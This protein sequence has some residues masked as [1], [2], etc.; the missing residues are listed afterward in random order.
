M[1]SYPS[2]AGLAGVAA[3]VGS[4]PRLKLI[5]RRLLI[6]VPVLFG[7]T[8][9][10]FFILDLLPGSA[11]QQ[12]L[13]PD[14]TA[15]QV[16]RLEAQLDLDQPAWQR[17]VRWIADV[18]KGDLGNSFASGQPVRQ[19]LAERLPVTGELVLCAFL[20]SILTAV[21][22]AVV[23]A[24]YPGRI[25]DR[26]ITLLSMAGL[27]AANYVIALLLVLL[28]SVSLRLFPAIGFTPIS[29]GLMKNLHSLALPVLAIALPLSC[30]YT[31]F[32]RGDLLAQLY[33]KDYVITAVAKGLGPWRVVIGHALRN[34]LFGLLTLVGLNIGALL[35]GTVVVEQIFA[36]PGIGQLLLQ[37]INTRDADVVQA[38]VLL[39]ALVTVVA[40][41]SVD[42]LYTALDPRVR[43][44]RE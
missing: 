12:L 30:F 41:L 13:G 7:V 16:A 29:V 2:G 11:A 40:N 10:T 3:Y 17:Y 34:S 9:L 27:C 25:V 35:G 39:V 22:A 28:L 38:I 42:V 24:R 37:G 1:A 5:G 44:E 4:S 21:P 26:F 18:A 20:L 6:A 14:A 23:A 8:L 33:E 32:L 19:L 15:Q 31:R 36:L 43:Y